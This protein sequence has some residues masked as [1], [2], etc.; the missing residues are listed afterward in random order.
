VCCSEKTVVQATYANWLRWREGPKADAVDEVRA[1]YADLVEL[2]AL[3]AEH[4]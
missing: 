1:L 4:R 3:S 2:K